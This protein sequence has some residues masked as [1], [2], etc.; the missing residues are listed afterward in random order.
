[1]FSCPLIAWLM[2]RPSFQHHMNNCSVRKA[3][4]GALWVKYDWLTKDR[5]TK[6]YG[7]GWWDVKVCLVAAAEA[8]AWVGMCV[9]A[10]PSPPLWLPWGWRWV[11]ELQGRPSS[12]LV[13]YCM[14][15]GWVVLFSLWRISMGGK[16]P[17]TAICL[18][19]HNH[20][21]D[22]RQH[23]ASISHSD[24]REGILPDSVLWRM[25]GTQAFKWQF[26]KLCTV[27]LLYLKCS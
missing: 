27:F 8:V 22:R 7:A 18:T 19:A 20:S 12:A 6:W 24:K 13:L 16:A 4:H 2:C 26:G 10:D 14:L 21:T 1:M 17:Q 5:M 9:I 11:H 25:M 15:M 3:H 23:L